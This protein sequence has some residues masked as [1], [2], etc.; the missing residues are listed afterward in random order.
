ML[1][2]LKKNRIDSTKPRREGL[3]CVIDKLQSLDKDSFEALAPFIDIVKI[4]DAIPILVPESVLQ[5]KIKFYHDFDILVSTGSA[6]TEYSVLENSF[7]KFAKQAIKLGFD[8]IEI[9]ENSIEMGLEQKKNVID[10]ILSTSSYMADGEEKN[11][12]FQW[13]VGKKDPRHQLDVEEM[14]SKIDEIMSIFREVEERWARVRKNKGREVELSSISSSNLMNINKMIPSN[15][16]I[17]SK[18]YSA[19]KIILEANQGINVGIYDEKGFV[20]WSYVGALTSKYSPSSFI[21]EAPIESQQS[22]LIAE[23]GQRVNLAEVNPEYVMSVESQRR[24]FLSKAAFE[25]SYL[26]KDPEGGPAAKFIYYIIRTRHPIDQGELRR[27]SHLPRR[28]IQ[29][30]IE[31]LKTQGIVL[32]RNSLDDARK[33]IYIPVHSDWL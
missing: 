2:D 29:S 17:N 3:T 33:K 32:E 16:I 26:R 9:G 25:V 23:F 12:S 18:D 20:K 7:D 13:K 30:A 28:T 19:N 21:F 6:L 14:L 11:I 24:G 15:T 4:Y 22:A 1:D 31:E 8:I 10:I 5:K 27:L